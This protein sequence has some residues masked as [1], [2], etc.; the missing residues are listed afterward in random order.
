MKTELIGFVNLIAVGITLNAGSVGFIYL[1]KTRSDERGFLDFFAENTV[2]YI[3]EW[4]RRYLVLRY[5]ILYIFLI[6]LERL[7]I[8]QINKKYCIESSYLRNTLETEQIALRN[9][10]DENIKNISR[11]K[12]NLIESC[13]FRHF[14]KISLLITFFGV[15]L[16]MLAGIEYNDPDYS[17]HKAL[18]FC[19]VFITCSILTSMISECDKSKFGYATECKGKHRKCW[20]FFISVTKFFLHPGK[21]KWLV[22]LIIFVITLNILNNQYI[23]TYFFETYD[24]EKVETWILHYSIFLLFFGLTAYIVLIIMK[25]IYHSYVN[26][27]KDLHDVYLFRSNIK[28]TIREKIERY[29]KLVQE[30]Q[31][32]AAKIVD[33][34]ILNNNNP[35]EIE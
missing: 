15:Y 34:K 27:S 24:E 19:E 18:I 8:K 29:E 3:H 16:L 33:E 11:Y 13:R 28:K 23:Y 31:K 1:D 9:K 4:T 35:F 17:Y 25:V 14:W 7:K 26:M 10:I 12:T 32:N 21:I 2:N 22:W 6:L 20:N 5:T 30:E